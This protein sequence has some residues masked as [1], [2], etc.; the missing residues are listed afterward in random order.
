MQLEEIK[1]KTQYDKFI[2]ENEGSFLQSYEWGEF[3][4]FFG[5]P[6]KR[7]LIK[8]KDDVILAASVFLYDMPFSKNYLYIPY[9][10]IIKKELHI[11]KADEAYKL[12]FKELKKE[13]ENN[14]SIFLKIEQDQSPVNLKS[15]GLKKS[16][17]D[18]Q[19]RETLI[20]DT[21]RDEEEMLKGMKQKTRYNIR[22]AEKKGVNIFEVTEKKVAF[23][24]FYKLLSE[25]SQR[26]GFNLHPKKYYENMVDMFFSSDSKLKQ[27]IFF[28]EY[29]GQIIACAL[30][31]YFG[32]RATFL[33]GASSDEFKNVMAPHLLHWQ[34][35]KKAHEDEIK[36]YDFWGIVTERTDPKKKKQW[37]GFSRFKMG[38]G[39]KVVEYE[40]AYDMVYKPFMYGLYKIVR[41]IR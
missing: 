32:K 12:L 29:Q 10:P 34:I 5:R 14:N 2:L 11:E 25:T 33:H 17:K 4:D 15:L 31:G 38:F 40:G 7:Y 22:L 28:A 18:I 26:N 19:A 27:K 35:I 24:M 13:A 1:D 9:G 3:Q 23:D 20:F 39:G 37:E 8:D 21:H 30:V 41:K 16:D 36:E 6:V